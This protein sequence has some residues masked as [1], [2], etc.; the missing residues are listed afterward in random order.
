MN[1]KLFRHV[2]VL[3]VYAHW[4]FSEDELSSVQ[5]SFT[6]WAYEEPILIRGH[7]G[8]IYHPHGD[9]YTLILVAYRRTSRRVEHIVYAF[10][11]P[12][13]LKVQFVHDC[14]THLDKLLAYAVSDEI[15]L[16]ELNKYDVPQ[17]RLDEVQKVAL[18]YFD[19]LPDDELFS[20]M[21]ALKLMWDFLDKQV[22]DH[23]VLQL[24][25][26]LSV[27]TAIIG[28]GNM[29]YNNLLVRGMGDEI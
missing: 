3:G 21:R 10:K 1:F 12:M 15:L 2:D 23:H 20:V 4:F 16:Y 19:N 28:A 11:S 6:Q 27:L 18:Q 5:S 26:V 9:G 17:S 8:V 24:Y 13:N 7:Q 29:R 25:G 14:L 22:F